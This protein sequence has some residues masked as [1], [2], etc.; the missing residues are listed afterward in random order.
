MG[1]LMLGVVLF[2]SLFLFLFLLRSL[3]TGRTGVRSL[4]VVS[5]PGLRWW[6]WCWCRA[7]AR[8]YVRVCCVIVCVVCHGVLFCVSS[9]LVTDTLQSLWTLGMSRR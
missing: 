9:Y 7:L 6:C 4:T 5:P 8:T 1:G 2:Q 3:P